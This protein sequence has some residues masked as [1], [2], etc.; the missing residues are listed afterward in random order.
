MGRRRA[1]TFLSNHSHVLVSL[2]QNSAMTMREIADRIGITERAVA[3]VLHDLEE[4]GVLA[5]RREGRRNVY[6]INPDAPLRHD[7][8]SHRTVG[9]LLGLAEPAAVPTPKKK[10]EKKRVGS[11]GK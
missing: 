7:V 8:E 11:D 4:A 9:D 5:R 3:Q 10:I 1:W 2:A 6:Q